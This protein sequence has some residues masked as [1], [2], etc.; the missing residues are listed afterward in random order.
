M[1]GSI[2]SG[3]AGCSCCVSATAC[4]SFERKVLVLTCSPERLASRAPSAKLITSPKASSASLML[5]LYTSCGADHLRAEHH[6]VIADQQGKICTL[7]V[8]FARLSRSTSTARKCELNSCQVDVWCALVLAVRSARA[9]SGLGR[10]HLQVTT[11]TPSLQPQVKN[12]LL[13]LIT[14]RRLCSNDGLSQGFQRAFC[15]RTRA[16]QQCQWTELCSVCPALTR[17]QSDR[18]LIYR[19][20]QANSPGEPVLRMFQ[21]AVTVAAAAITRSWHSTCRRYRSKQSRSSAIR[22][23][24]PLA[25]CRKYA[26][27][28]SAST[29]TAISSTRGKGCINTACGFS[30]VHSALSM[31]SLPLHSS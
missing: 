23:Y 24:N 22:T 9:S 1:S 19:Q 29:S 5:Q 27:R 7:H 14:F 20:A 31:M 6:A 28:G 12:C 11:V 26:A 3:L 18:T 15:S 13:L 17:Y 16:S 21:G 2:A 8:Y 25:A 4:W 10:S 30:L